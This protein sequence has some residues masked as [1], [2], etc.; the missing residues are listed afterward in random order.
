[1][2]ITQEVK[3]KSTYKMYKACWK[4][5]LHKKLELPYKFLLL[6]FRIILVKIDKQ[7]IYIY[8][9][10]S[11]TRNKVFP[12]KDKEV[13]LHETNV[14][15]SLWERESKPERNLWGKKW[16]LLAEADIS[17]IS[18]ELMISSVFSFSIQTSRHSQNLLIDIK[19][20]A[21]KLR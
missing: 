19:I 21:I 2:M 11:S 7:T 5:C 18:F 4:I 17:A 13:L 10:L 14:L 20:I 15:I 3:N 12:L 16:I 8:M 6:G 1:M 9:L